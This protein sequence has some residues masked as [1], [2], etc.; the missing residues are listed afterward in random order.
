MRATPSCASNLDSR[1]AESPPTARHVARS[2]AGE[3]RGSAARVS[4]HR[5]GC[6]SARDRNGD[7]SRNSKPLSDTGAHKEKAQKLS[8]TQDQEIEPAQSK[9]A[10]QAK[11]EMGDPTA[12]TDLSGEQMG[13][14]HREINDLTAQEKRA[15][16]GHTCAIDDNHA[17]AGAAV[18]APDARKGDPRAI[19]HPAARG[20]SRPSRS[21]V[22][23]VGS[24]R[25]SATET[26]HR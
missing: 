19:D 25:E 7:L 16:D 23:R 14:N 13:S 1:A 18:D 26:T 10:E 20:R 6:A 8:F 21:T 22:L 15:V 17:A 12:A 3:P 5:D 24:G 2:A 11:N 9:R 4:E